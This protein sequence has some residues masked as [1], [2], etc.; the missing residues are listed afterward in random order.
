MTREY[1][2]G[3]GDGRG[4][5]KKEAK[6]QLVM[7]FLEYRYGKT[8]EE[9]RGRIYRLNDKLLDNLLTILLTSQV[10]RESN[11]CNSSRLSVFLDNFMRGMGGNEE[12][13]SS[14]SSC[15]S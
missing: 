7:R 1:R 2:K 9:S 10:S 13:T 14:C 6:R 8:D 3:W 5:G 12:R 15:S 11:E 4:Y